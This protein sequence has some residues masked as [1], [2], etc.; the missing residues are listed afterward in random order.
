MSTE[1]V[2]G[3]TPPISVTLPTPSEVQATDTLFE[4]LKRQNQ[5]EPASE[6][7]KR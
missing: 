1:Q 5:F 3:L 6:D 7:A 2:W 4:E